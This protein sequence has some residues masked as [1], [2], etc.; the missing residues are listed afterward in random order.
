MF[1][2]LVTL[3]VHQGGVTGDR[4]SSFERMEDRHGTAERAQG[5][6]DGTAG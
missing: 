5:V 1:Q 6:F 3:D 2:A 4:T